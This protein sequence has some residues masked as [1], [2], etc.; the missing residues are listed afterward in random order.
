M[1]LEPA[2]VLEKVTPLLT[3]PWKNWFNLVSA[4]VNN[5]IARIST[6]ESDIAAIDTRVT[7]SESDIASISSRISPIVQ[8][9][10]TT[11]TID[12]GNIAADN[13]LNVDVALAG[14]VR[15]DTNPASVIV[16]PQAPQPGII[17][18]AFVQAANNVRIRA[19]N[20]SPAAIDPGSL[21]FSILVFDI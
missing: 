7:T 21:G 2:P 4:N 15:D 13:F 11:A 12:F 14:V 18:T 8:V 9:Y 19:V 16:M 3:I 20:V 6:A 17:F 10:H 1:S 5:L